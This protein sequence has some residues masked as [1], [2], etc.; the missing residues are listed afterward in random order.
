MR[1]QYGKLC[2]LVAT[3]DG[4]ISHLILFSFLNNLFIICNQLFQSLRW[5]WE[6]KQVKKVT[7]EEF[8]ITFSFRDCRPSPTYFHLVYFWYS[9]SFLIMR[10]FAVSLLAAHIDEES[11]KPIRFLRTVPSNMWNEETKRFFADVVCKRVAL[12]GMQ[13][14]FLTRK[15]ILSVAGTII[16]YEL[17][18]MQFNRDWTRF[19]SIFFW[20]IN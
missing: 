3:V 7:L 19:W 4:K 11:Q 12:S 18:L 10:T 17:V 2:D 16:T 9:L 8:H 5:F 15:L 14:F 20:T 13:F 1:T 6:K